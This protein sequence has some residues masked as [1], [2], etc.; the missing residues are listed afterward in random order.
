[1]NNEPPGE[2][3]ETAGQ[4]TTSTAPLSFSQL[5]L[6]Q[7]KQ[8]YD[9]AVEIWEANDSGAGYVA[10]A[11]MAAEEAA[12]TVH[13][14]E[15]SAFTWLRVRVWRC[16]GGSVVVLTRVPK[17]DPYS[18]QSTYRTRRTLSQRLLATLGFP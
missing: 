15:H 9:R 1:M 2:L 5:T 13:K 6:S 3:F 8:L 4:R 7:R 16:H 11:L 12:V 17:Q 14:V 18:Y 10:S